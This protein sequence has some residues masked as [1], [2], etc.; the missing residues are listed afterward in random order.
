MKIVAFGHRKLT[1][2]DTCANLLIEAFRLKYPGINV[3]K[4]GFSDKLKEI[5]FELFKW[6]GIKEPEYYE[7]FPHLK[8]TQLP[9]KL[10][11]KLNT[12]RDIWIEVANRLRE[13]YEPIWIDQI[14]KTKSCDLL[15]IKDVRFPNEAIAIKQQ[16]GILIKVVR[17]NIPDTDDEADIALKDWSD[18]DFIIDN[19][20]DIKELRLQLLVLESKLIEN[21]TIPPLRRY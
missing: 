1:G 19:Y 5:C 8:D 21:V 3:K 13:V 20:T 15:F 18:W 4:R 7:E 17:P 6:T 9:I 11:D 2:K 12:M 14:L 16:G 10:N